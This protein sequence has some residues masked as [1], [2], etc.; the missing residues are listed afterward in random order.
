MSPRSKLRYLAPNAITATSIVLGMISIQ[1]SLDGHYRSAA[2]WAMFCAFTDKLDGFVARAFKASSA[3]GAQLDSFADFLSFGVAP[4]TAVYGFFRATPALGWTS[5]WQAYALPLL[6]LSYVLCVAARLARFN[7]TVD[8]HPGGGRFFYGVAS[9]MAGGAL[10]ALFITLLKYGDPGWLPADP[11]G[12]DWRLLGPLRLDGAMPL[13]P[14]ALPLFGYA[15]VST[16]RV[17]KLGRTR[18]PMVDALQV[19]NLTAGYSL[20]LARR[21]PE[22]LI[23]GAIAYLLL[24]VY[25]H[26]TSKAAREARLPPLFEDQPPPVPAD[27]SGE[28][29]PAPAS[30]AAAH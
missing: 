15:M 22:Y 6:A 21:V 24:S 14:F 23:A 18:R 27:G 17:P 26:L 29:A 20:G 11:I 16:L 4:A 25:Y 7:I 28:A 12:S 19:A 1:R 3:F 30:Q 9:T 5:G 2:W 13:L 8:T 10:C